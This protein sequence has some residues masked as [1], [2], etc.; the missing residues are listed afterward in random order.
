MA[1]FALATDEVLL[2]ASRGQ[3]A[4]SGL[5]RWRQGV[6][7]WQGELAG[8]TH[9]LSAL[10]VHPHLP[11][12]YGTAGE[13]PGRL[14]AWRFGADGV[15]VLADVSTMGLEPAH[16]AVDPAGQ[17]LI[18][19]NYQDSSLALW[20]LGVDGSVSG[21]A[22]IVTLTGSGPDPERQE[23]AHPHQALFAADGKVVVID[24]GADCLRWFRLDA[25]VPSLT[26]AGLWR[27]P[28]GSGPRHGVFL[29]DGRLAVAGELGNMLLIGSG[30]DW[31]MAP[32]TGHSRP[33]HARFARNY[34]GDIA[35]GP[36][37]I[38]HLANRSL[39]TLTSFDVSGAAPRRVGEVECGVDW[40]QHLL[41]HR[42]HVLVAGWDTGRV[43][44][45]PLRDGVAGAPETLFDCA[46]ACW[47]V[48]LGP[49]L[50]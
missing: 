24:L 34:P 39:S 23:A 13:G 1:G 2:V 9:D 26:P 15:E 31:Q 38:V 27:L 49:G 10:A 40:P 42:D 3:E 16:V 48:R 29:E 7:G 50:G 32:A 20:R 46:G 19:A 30:D 35:A 41:V 45:H 11:V 17:V 22:Q 4:T 5:W 25:A 37:G 12:V 28:P 47:I 21:A 44:A 14:L 6:G 43:V 36:G 33:G 8:A 18:V